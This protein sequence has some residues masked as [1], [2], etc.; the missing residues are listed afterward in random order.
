MLH[1]L[2]QNQARVL[3]IRVCVGY[4]EE[5]VLSGKSRETAFH[6]VN[7]D[8]SQWISKLIVIPPQHR[9]HDPVFLFPLLLLY[10]CE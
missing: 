5:K 1:D 3:R 10:L 9:P 8:K 2:L 6:D 7:I 4:A